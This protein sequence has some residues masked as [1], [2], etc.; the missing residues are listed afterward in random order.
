[1]KKIYKSTFKIVVLLMLIWGCVIDIGPKADWNYLGL[2]ESN[3]AT[4]NSIDI[5]WYNSC[6]IFVSTRL[7]YARGIDAFLLMS[8]NEGKDWDT[9]E[10]AF[11]VGSRYI[12]ICFDPK[13]PN[14]IYIVNGLF[15]KMSIDGGNTWNIISSDIFTD[16]GNYITDLAINPMDCNILYVSTWGN[17][18]GSV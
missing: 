17:L 6:K 9:L 18:G 12:K 7:D 1:M 3:I 8:D 14:I 2:S 15:I 4:I 13:D 10:T 5:P 16:I 11:D